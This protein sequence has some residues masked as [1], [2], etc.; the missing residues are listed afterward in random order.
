MT[1][2]A[3]AMRIVLLGPPGA[4][5]GTQARILEERFDARQISTG[6][7]LRK[8]RVEKTALGT[9]AQAYMD[10]GALVPDD[11]VIRMM[12]GELAGRSSFILD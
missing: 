11:L 9:E 1:T 2:A 4:G 12:E 6:D 8:H 7:I 5:K 3:P 10:R